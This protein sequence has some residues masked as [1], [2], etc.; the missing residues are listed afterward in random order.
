MR[1]HD[2]W[3]HYDYEARKG[4][5]AKYYLGTAQSFLE[6]GAWESALDSN[7]IPPPLQSVFMVSVWRMWPDATLGD[8]RVIQ[9]VLGTCAIWFAYLIGVS[10]GGR[11]SGLV[12]AALVAFDP[13][14]VQWT[15]FLLAES[16]YIVLLFGFLVALLRAVETQRLGWSLLCGV[17][18]GL[19]VLMKPFPMLLALLI[20]AI[21]L[22]RSPRMSS[23]KVGGVLLLSFLAVVSPWIIRNSIRCGRLCGISTN[24]GVVLAQ[25]NFLELDARLP[26]MRYWEQLSKTEY[27]RDQGVEERYQTVPDKV[28]KQD[29]NQRDHAYARRAFS[30]MAAHPIHFLRN[31]CVK[32]YNGLFYPRS[33]RRVY[34]YA[35]RPWI[36]VVGLLGLGC[37]VCMEWGA[38]RWV[39]APVQVY[40]ILFTGLF[41][42]T[43]WGRINFPS[44][45]LLGFFVAY[46]VGLISRMVLVR[47]RQS[48]GREP[49]GV[50]AC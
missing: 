28:G 50:E 9:A 2:A 49:D 47:K 12:A 32:V 42:I 31:Y 23:L 21:L 36:I 13:Y 45:L 5:V 7:F 6:R 30:Y 41:H 24:V 11:V 10:M 27:W 25:S 39:M 44:K 43:R 20:P 19:T 26:E 14:L 4:D 22:V 38:P 15:G 1:L 29:W 48:M 18:L 8:L 34:E 46:L 40:F 37:Y 33:A 17:L 35:V 3:V 16:N